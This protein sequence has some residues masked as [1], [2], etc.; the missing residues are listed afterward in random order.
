MVEEGG[1]YYGVKYIMDRPVR[2]PSTIRGKS[3]APP[4]GPETHRQQGVATT[5]PL[6]GRAW[7]IKVW[8]RTELGHRGV[9]SGCTMPIR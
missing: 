9:E 2:C 4:Q 5:P 1:K 8:T 7:L 6:M 3:P